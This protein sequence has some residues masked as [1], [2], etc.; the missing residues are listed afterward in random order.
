VD[1]VPVSVGDDSLRFHGR[2]RRRDVL[3]V[4]LSWSEEFARYLLMWLA[5]L[6]AAYGFKIKAHFAL[7][8]VVNRLPAGAR[9]IV[10]TLVSILVCALLCVFVYKAVEIT[11]S[12]RNQIGPATQLS[13]AVPY[14]SGVVGGILMLYYIALN[15]W[16]EWRNADETGPEKG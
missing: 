7:F 10:S 3:H 14:S 11:Y 16:H 1:R 8:F 12:V 2:Y 4:S 6:S 13:K 5:M 9:K 15:A